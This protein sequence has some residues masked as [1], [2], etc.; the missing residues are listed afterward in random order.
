[1]LGSG[2]L[3]GGVSLAT[4]GTLSGTLPAGDAVYTFTVIARGMYFCA[5][6][7]GYS[8]IVGDPVIVPDAG[9]GNV[10]AGPVP[11]STG[12]GMQRRTR[13]GREARGPPAL[14]RW[15]WSRHVATAPAPALTWRP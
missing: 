13:R 8:I 5:I 10:D 1:M 3:P 7:R 15:R 12:G 4:D 11:P 2:T 9:M 14:R 6:T